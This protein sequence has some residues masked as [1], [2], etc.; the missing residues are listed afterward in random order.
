MSARTLNRLSAKCCAAARKPGEYPD[1]GGLMLLVDDGGNRRWVMRISLSGRRVKRGL[2]S[3][4]EVSLAGAR[5]RAAEIRRAAREGRDLSAEQQVSAAR[6]A[7]GL[8]TLRE[9]FADY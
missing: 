8:T 3:Y 2:G 7:A 5:K 1:G 6:A 9:A 4:P